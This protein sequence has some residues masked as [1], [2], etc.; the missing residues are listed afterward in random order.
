LRPS[1][2]VDVGALW[3]ANGK[4]VLLPPTPPTVDPITGQIIPGFVEDY[5]G[6]TPSPRISVGIGVNWNSPF[7]PFRID[8]AK[9]LKKAEGDRDQLFQFNVGTQ[10]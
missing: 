7:G 9:A 3:G 1:A 2:Y 6:D 4:D 8:I 10:F 5:V